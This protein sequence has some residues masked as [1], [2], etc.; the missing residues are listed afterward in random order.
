MH[1]FTTVREYARDVNYG[2]PDPPFPK[3]VYRTPFLS[4]MN[5]ISKWL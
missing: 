2:I 4:V 3:T 1:H 5:L